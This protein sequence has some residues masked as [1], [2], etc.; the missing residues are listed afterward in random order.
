MRSLLFRGFY[1]V[2][3]P[4][5]GW[6]M[7]HWGEHAVLLLAGPLLSLGSILFVAGLG[8]AAAPRPGAPVESR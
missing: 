5:V 3:G 1:L 2:I 6:G 7:D 4:A 8:R